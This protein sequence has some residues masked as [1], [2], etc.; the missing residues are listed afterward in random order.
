P[1]D[2]CADGQR[3]PGDRDRDPEVEPGSVDNPCKDVAPV[4]IGAHPV[5]IR[6]RGGDGERIGFDR[7]VAAN[8]RSGD[9]QGTNQSERPETDDRRGAGP[10]YPLPPGESTGSGPLAG[11]RRFVT[12]LRQET[13]RRKRAIDV[14]GGR[15]HA[16]TPR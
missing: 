3:E 6:W 13:A 2:D 9:R 8:P 1:A 14:A 10:P 16:R 11:N 15:R 7:V 12:R 4:L 5:R